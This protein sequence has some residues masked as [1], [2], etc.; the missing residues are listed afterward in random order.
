MYA[1]ITLTPVHCVPVATELVGV[2]IHVKFKLHWSKEKIVPEYSSYV[3]KTKTVHMPGYPIG[4]INSSNQLHF[5]S[6]SYNQF[7][8][9]SLLFPCNTGGN[10]ESDWNVC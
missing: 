5:A 9:L 2:Q 3:V 4:N 1:H 6:V 10:G 8:I 7:K